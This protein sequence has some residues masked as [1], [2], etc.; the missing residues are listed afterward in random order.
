MTTLK[1]RLRH[2]RHEREFRRVM[3]DASPAMR[4]ELRA[5]AARHT[6]MR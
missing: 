1:E 5:L 4:A 3:A 2:R 6:A